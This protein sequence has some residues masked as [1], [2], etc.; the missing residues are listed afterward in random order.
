MMHD[1]GFQLVLLLH[2][3]YSKHLSVLKKKFSGHKVEQDCIFLH[4]INFLFN[5]TQKYFKCLMDTGVL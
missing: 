3:S 1:H 5:K 2:F 4:I